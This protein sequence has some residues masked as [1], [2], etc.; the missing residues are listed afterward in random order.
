MWWI[1]GYLQEVDGGGPPNHPPTVKLVLDREE[2]KYSRVRVRLCVPLP[3]GA[4]PFLYPLGFL[5]STL[6]PYDDV[7]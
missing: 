5:G 1:S 3:M 7:R 4:D 2:C 6:G